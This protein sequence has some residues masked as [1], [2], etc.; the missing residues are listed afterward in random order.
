MDLNGQIH[1]SASL[2]PGSQ[3]TNFIRDGMGP[4][5]CLSASGLKMEE[6]GCS[7]TTILAYEI[8]HCR[9]KQPYLNYVYP[10]DI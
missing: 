9:K 6:T 3:V 2:P 1:T 5:F 4:R 10:L 7:E 8:I